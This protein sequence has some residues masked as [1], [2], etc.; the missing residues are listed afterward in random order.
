MCIFLFWS[1]DIV[2][3]NL[4]K[5]IWKKIK[6]EK[7]VKIKKFPSCPNFIF[8]QKLFITLFSINDFFA[9]IAFSCSL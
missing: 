1:I 4:T 2:F 5:N 9:Q 8:D 6:I 3:K 7:K